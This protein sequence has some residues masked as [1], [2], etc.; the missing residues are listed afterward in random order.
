MEFSILLGKRP[1]DDITMIIRDNGAPYDIFQKTEQGKYT[2]REYFIDSIT[3]SF[4]RRTYWISGD[5][6][7]MIL[8]VGSL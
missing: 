4:P 8:V 7:R 6:N 5:E 3:T 1:D 2:F